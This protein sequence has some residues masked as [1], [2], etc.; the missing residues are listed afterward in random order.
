MK[1][2]SFLRRLDALRMPVECL[3]VRCKLDVK[4]VEEWFSMCDA[5]GVGPLRPPTTPAEYRRLQATAKALKICSLT[6]VSS[7]LEGQALIQTQF[8]KM[9]ANTA[10]TL[11]VDEDQAKLWWPFE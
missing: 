5:I 2:R 4:R 7:A 10:A 3:A 6:Q 8:D 11:L 1:M 9:V